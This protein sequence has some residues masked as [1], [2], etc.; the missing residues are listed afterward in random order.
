MNWL[1]AL[2]MNWA[3]TALPSS[4]WNLSSFVLSL[5]NGVSQLPLK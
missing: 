4:R 3:S 5:S 2:H 1:S